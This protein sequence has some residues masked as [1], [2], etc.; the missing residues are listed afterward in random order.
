MRIVI[1]GSYPPRKCGIATFTHDLYQSLTLQQQDV[2]ICAVMD[3]TENDFPR[4]VTCRI[5]RD[6][7]ADYI[8]S[9]K[10]INSRNYDCCIIQHEFGI[11][12][13]SAGD[14]ILL[15]AEK[16]KIPIITNLHT[17][18]ETPNRTEHVVLKKLAALSSIVTVMTYRA[19]TMLKTV[20]DISPLK[21]RM[22]PHG[23]PEFTITSKQAREK[24][25]LE[26]K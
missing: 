2:E 24:L 25:G 14:F 26:N 3:G 6:I 5:S 12:G 20:Y 7:E 23:I 1:I 13:N 4:E 8:N 15:L 16:L 21:I 10:V 11:F 9:A 18:L 22:V 17:V 19:I